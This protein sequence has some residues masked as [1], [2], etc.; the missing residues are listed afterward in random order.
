MIKN[1]ILDLES[2]NKN[3]E[4]YLASATSRVV[5]FFLDRIGMFIFI[6]CFVKIF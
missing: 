1:E 4:K 2:V 6:F 5:N 3:P